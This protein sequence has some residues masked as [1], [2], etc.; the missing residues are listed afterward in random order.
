MDWTEMAWRS[1][2][3]Q[4]LL[5]TTE[6]LLL[7]SPCPPSVPNITLAVVTGEVSLTWFDNS[8]VNI[9]RGI[10]AGAERTHSRGKRR[11]EN[12]SDTKKAQENYQNSIQART[13]QF[14]AG[15]LRPLMMGPWLS[16]CERRPQMAVMSVQNGSACFCHAIHKSLPTADPGQEEEQRLV[17]RKVHHIRMI[18]RC[19]CFGPMCVFQCF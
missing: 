7:T 19:N 12:N 17:V 6:T 2:H 16:I 5:F 9:K 11:K 3:L 1:V 4:A 10:R 18:M 13:W 14:R 8:G 15:P